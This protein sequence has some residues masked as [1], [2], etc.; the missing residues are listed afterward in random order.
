MSSNAG[1]V[2]ATSTAETTSDMSATT[3]EVLARVRHMVP[4]MLD[5]FHKGA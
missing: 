2:P 3:R 4:P 1:P 5:K